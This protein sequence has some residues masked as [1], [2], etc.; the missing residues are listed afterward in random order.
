MWLGASDSRGQ[1]VR[2]QGHQGIED[3]W[4]LGLILVRSDL[5]ALGV[6]CET[7]K[8]CEERYKRTSGEEEQK[9]QTP[10]TPR[11]EVQTEQRPGK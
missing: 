2:L 11:S 6:M 10:E 7:S 3:V 4:I 8:E 9:R 5:P 1:I